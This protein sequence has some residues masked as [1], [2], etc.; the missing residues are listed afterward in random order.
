VVLTAAHCAQ[1][2]PSAYR[3]ATNSVDW[4]NASRRQVSGVSRVIVDPAYNPILHDADVALLA[5]SQPTTAPELAFITGGTVEPGTGAEI[6]GW[7]KTIAGSPTVPN[8]LQYAATV[9]QSATTCSVSPVYHS[10]QQLCALDYPFD[11]SGT[12]NGDSG[13]PLLVSSGGQWVEVGI[14]S[15]GSL[16]CQTSVPQ[17]FTAIEPVSSWLER[18]LRALSGPGSAPAASSASP[19][20]SHRSSIATQPVPLPKLLTS[21]AASGS[22]TVRPPVV[23]LSP[24]GSEYVAGPSQNGQI[25]WT[26]WTQTQAI[27]T[28]DEWL[29]DCRPDCA[30]GGYHAHAVRLRAY[31]P[32]NGRFTRFA[33]TRR[34]DGR[35][36][37]RTYKL[38]EYHH[39]WIWR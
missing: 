39:N 15:Y 14:T 28:G 4:T 27:G 3:V 16:D 33:I 10:A 26:S 2:A 35:W 29:D 31:R 11:N 24:D 38:V 7:G 30:T 22:Y 13:G 21:L 34:D 9:I 17:Y 5:L 6:A 36:R 37:A 12:C 25:T 32:D 18:E 20:S 1:G 19:P 23:Y 8:V